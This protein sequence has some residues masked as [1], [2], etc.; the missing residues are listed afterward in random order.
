ML[1]KQP[2]QSLIDGL[3]CLQALAGSKEGIGVRAMARE[4]NLEPTRTHRILKTLAHL[5]LAQQGDDGQYRP[6]SAVHVLA[7]QA[8]RGSGLV[9]VA[10]PILDRLVEQLT[11]PAIVAMGVLWRDHVCYLYHGKK[12]V[13]G[14]AALGHAVLYPATRSGIGLILL[15]HQPEDTVRALYDGKEI[16]GFGSLAELNR[17]LAHIRKIKVAD[18]VRA[19]TDR[20]VA[21]GIG[22][23][24]SS[25][26]TYAGAFMSGTE[27]LVAHLKMAADDIDVKLKQYIS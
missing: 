17:E 19:N 2:N 23:N 25:A 24:P 15:A 13:T 3:S 4:L 1:P 16:P 5:G 11:L 21:V 7:A 22:D 20:A 6:G 8:L 18:L 27:G 26:I 10:T 12:G 9:Q 14:T